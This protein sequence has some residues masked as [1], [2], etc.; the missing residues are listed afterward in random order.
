LI[1]R[2]RHLVIWAPNPEMLRDRMRDVEASLQMFDWQPCKPETDA[3]LEDL[4][5]SY[6]PSRPRWTASGRR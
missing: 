2:E 1:A 5:N 3:E 4:V 6:F